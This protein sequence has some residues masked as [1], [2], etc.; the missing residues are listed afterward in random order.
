MQIRKR[1]LIVEDEKL[2]A[3]RLKR[4]LS[5][6][7]PDYHVAAVLESVSDVVHWLTVNPQPDLL[8]LD[9]RLSDGLSFEIFEHTDVSCPVIFTTAFDEYA[10][11]AFKHNSV[12]Y[13][14]KPVDKD[15]LENAVV[16]LENFQSGMQ[17]SVEKL[18]SF[19]KTNHVDYRTRFLLPF[20]DGYK[21]LLV[22]DV[23]Y[24]YLD[25]KIMYARLT[26]G[27]EQVL[28]QSMEELEQQLDPKLFFRA[29]RQIIIHIDS[30][31]QIVNS[32]NGK[33]RITLRRSKDVE[34]FIS[35]DK[36]PQFKAWMD[37]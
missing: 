4:F 27:G 20:K 26:S 15:E 2:N 11:R 28:S 25:Q 8:L 9:I 14:L 12:D 23:E 31:G 5:E 6:L 34:I 29:N 30:V 35:R 24:F 19:L 16:R 7:R 17:P 13:L 22:A 36:A 18:L 1:I 32:F 21:T 37:S 3:D 10:V 33:L